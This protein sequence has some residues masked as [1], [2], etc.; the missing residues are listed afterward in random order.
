MARVLCLPGVYRAPPHNTPRILMFKKFHNLRVSQKLML[1][2]VFFMLPDSIMLYLF[3]TGINENIQFGQLEQV[4]NQYQRPLERLLELIP[5]HRLLARSG[6]A[7][8]NDQK[9]AAKQSEIDAAFDALIQT[10]AQAGLKLQFT[11]EGLAKRGR[12]GCD[13]GSLQ[14]RWV[15]LKSQLGAIAPGT[16]DQQHL[17]LIADIR[18]MIAHAG[19]TSNLIL[20]PELDSYYLMDATLMAL[21][22]TQ[23]RLGQ[24]MLDGANV[25]GESGNVAK[26]GKVRLAI[27]FA[28]LKED[29]LDR[30]VSS[31][32]TSLSQVARFHGSSASFKTRVPPALKEYIEAATR[33]NDLTARIAGDTPSGITVEQYLSAGEAAR[34]ASFKFWQ[35][36]DDELDGILQN[37]I[38]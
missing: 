12:A 36:A 9:L 34:A 29:D 4:G 28:Q 11:P 2:S 3:I 10:D 23:D 31:T 37:R 33:F 25:L 17:Q 15:H 13:A 27:G 5:Q 19:D 8:G 7:V 22:Q 26:A 16:C 18:S 32:E 30:I 14:G 20:D 24:V 1:V 35:I 6:R 38:E 21:P